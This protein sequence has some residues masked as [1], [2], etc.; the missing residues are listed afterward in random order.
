MRC[1]YCGKEM[2]EGLIQSPQ[3]L[4]WIPGNKR[5]VLGRARFHEG[6]LVLSEL[7]F[8]RGSAVVAWLCRE[9][10]KMVIDCPEE[11]REEIN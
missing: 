11:H 8:L 5:K 2:E 6:A 10:G 4:S 1:P 3:E 9:C 7:S